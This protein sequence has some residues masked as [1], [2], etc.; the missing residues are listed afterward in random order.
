MEATLP[1]LP[2]VME[3]R[4]GAVITSSAI[5]QATCT[6]E[7]IG[8]F[9]VAFTEEKE[10]ALAEL[11]AEESIFSNQAASIVKEVRELCEKI[12]TIVPSLVAKIMAHR[13]H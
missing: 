2:D 4:I 1:R 13:G 3:A 6:G 8:S 11:R 7:D 9:L 5:R 10:Q 12:D